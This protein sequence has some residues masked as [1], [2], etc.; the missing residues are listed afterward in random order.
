LNR[1]KIIVLA[2]LAALDLI[3]AGFVWRSFAG[4]AEPLV[5]RPG[6]AILP[7]S[8]LELVM[9]ARGDDHE[10]LARPLFSKTRRPSPSPQ[11]SAEG[12]NRPPPSPPA[13]I[14]LYAVIL[15]GRSARTFICSNAALEGKWLA[16]GETFENWTV[17]SIAPQEVTLRHDASLIRIGLAYNGVSPIISNSQPSLQADAEPTNQPR[18]ASIP[19]P[20]TYDDVRSWKH[21]GR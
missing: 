21:G 12:G 6:L 2:G 9:P 13:G 5:T 17:D 20:P 19:M 1:L 16:A 18:S 10:T 3:A 11:A 15:S 4:G 7:T 8:P 14:K